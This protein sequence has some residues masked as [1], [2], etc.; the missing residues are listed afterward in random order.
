M[1]DAEQKFLFS[2]LCTN[3]KMLEYGSG[4]STNILENKVK[5]LVSIEH[6]QKWYNTVTQNT[7]KAIILFHESNNYSPPH[8]GTYK[9]FKEYIESPILYK[10]YDIILIDGRARYYCAKFA[11]EQL[12]HENT[13]YFIHDFDL[14]EQ[15]MIDRGREKYLKVLDFFQIIDNVNA[16]YLFKSK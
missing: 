3:H 16:L 1:K 9:E 10:P 13:K 14:D 8:D 15:K 12:S 11:H 4:E 5:Q 2:H 7:S 6:E